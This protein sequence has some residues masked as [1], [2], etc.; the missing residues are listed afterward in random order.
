MPGSD[1]LQPWVLQRIVRAYAGFG[2]FLEE[3]FEEISA[4]WAEVAKM[5]VLVE[6]YGFVADL[7]NSFALRYIIKWQPHC[8][9]LVEN[10]TEGP[11]VHFGPFKV[12]LATQDLGRHADCRSDSLLQFDLVI[13]HGRQP[14]IRELN[15]HGPTVLLV[16]HQKVLHLDIAMNHAKAVAVGHSQHHLE[17]EVLGEDLSNRAIQL[18]EE[19]AKILHSKIHDIHEIPATLK[20]VLDVHGVGVVHNLLAA[21]EHPLE[22]RS[23][24]LRLTHA[25]LAKA[26]DDHLAPLDMVHALEYSG[27]PAEPVELALD[28]V[29]PADQALGPFWVGIAIAGLDLGRALL[30]I[31]LLRLL[32]VI[33]PAV[34]ESVIPGFFCV[35]GGRK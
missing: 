8:Q 18:I 1:A 28:L 19:A 12:V 3:F 27:L 34:I 10:D 15:Q 2:V 26:L 31:L 6:V 14:K 9:Q 21:H 32:L 13:C 4:G 35:E 30:C 22:P 17:K 24:N 5:P 11:T 20:G 7:V 33:A 23:L 16:V 29:A 25:L